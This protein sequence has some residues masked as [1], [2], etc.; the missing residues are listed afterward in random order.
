MKLG[1]MICAFR[2]KDSIKGII[3]QYEGI[4]DKIVVAV[5][6]KSWKGNLEDEG[7]FE[8]ALETSATVLYDFWKEEHEQRNYAMEYLR[9]M[10]YVIISHC[11]TYFTKSDLR[12][13]KK[14]KLEDLHYTCRV[15]TYFRDLETVIDPN[16]SL[17]TII[18]RSDA[19]FN[20]MINIEGQD[21]NPKEL[22]ITCYHL[23]WTGSKNKIRDKITS[24]SHAAEI[25]V[26]WLEN[27]WNN[28]SA[29]INLA[30][31]NA[32][33]YQGLRIDSLPLEIRAM[34]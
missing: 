9:D 33:D 17:P 15:L 25:S 29:V 8:E 27:V 28:D 4:A 19:E 22:P 18:V 21:T 2:A 23:S 12:K 30:P 16:I 3:K 7:T 34:L 6:K 14:M 26:D 1:V 13:L 31:T 5:S 20:F 24:Y 10:D 11:D 32:T